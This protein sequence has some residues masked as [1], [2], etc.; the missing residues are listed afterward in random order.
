LVA[1]AAGAVAAADGAVAAAGAAVVAAATSLVGT[2]V[3]VA[4]AHPTR[5]LI[6]AITVMANQIARLIC[7]LS[8]FLSTGD[9]QWPKYNGKSSRRGHILYCLANTGKTPIAR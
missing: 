7:P 9:N 4:W 6:I 5:K 3:G 2:A 8:S 1:A